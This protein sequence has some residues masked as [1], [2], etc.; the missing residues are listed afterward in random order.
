ML[1]FLDY[2]IILVYFLM[3]I[4]I[5][6]ISLKK[7]SNETDFLVAGRRLGYGLYVP[8][9]TAVVL[10][11]A[12]TF[13]SSTL[14]YQY[15]IS[16]LWLVAMIGLGI[17][18]MGIF[19]SGKL[20]KLK[21][22]SVSELLG[23]RFGKSSR[24]ISGLIM[25]VYDIMVSVTAIVAIGVM[26][27]A[28]FGWSSVNSI[29]VGGVI[30]VL[31]TMLGGMWAV[32]LTDVIQ[33]WIM[34]I[35]IILILMPMGIFHAGGLAE[36]SNRVNPEFLSLTNVGGKAIFAYFL[37]Y[38]FGMMIGQDIWQRAFTAKNEKTLRRGTIYAGVLC[39][40][41]GIAGAVIGMVAS[42]VLPGLSDPQQAL[43]Q[44]VLTVLPT[45][46]VGVLLA[47]VSSA[48]MSTAS[49]TI[50]ASSTI[51]VNDF[52]LS[53]SKKIRSDKDIIKLT[54]IVTLVVG[55]IAIFIS[56]VLQDII[57]AL[58][59]AYALLSGS[60]FIPVIAA[61]FFK[62]V[63]AKVTLTSIIISAVV[64]I[65][66]LI[67]EGVSSLNAI[68]FGLI[69]GALVMFIGSLVQTKQSTNQQYEE[70]IE[71]KEL[72]QVVELER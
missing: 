16:G 20:S 46:L 40:I 63:S 18:G 42:V 49:G 29:L 2:G 36:I 8:A 23:N 24:Y 59:V 48:V 31:Y 14:G 28:L 44:L 64:V 4:G 70:N 51:I 30:V 65:G 5:G 72:E 38:F 17:L 12:S 26:F 22:F 35:G 62:N 10:G 32:T 56:L 60:I 66:D 34:F 41:Y 15:G 69:A 71:T 11:G 25:T 27:T 67:I 9:M 43:P 39:I 3:L 13:G 37:L 47:A 54:R 53:R 19:F 57:V 52:I 7:I 21:I 6:V 55:G 68:I 33:F 50:M 1:S 61:L 45:G 58:D